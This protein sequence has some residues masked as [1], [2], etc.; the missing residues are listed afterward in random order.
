[1]SLRFAA[2]PA[3]NLLEAVAMRATPHP[4]PKPHWRRRSKRAAPA[5]EGRRLHVGGGAAVRQQH[6]GAGD[7][8]V[9]DDHVLAA[10]AVVCGCMRALAWLCMRGR[11]SPWPAGPSALG[12]NALSASQ[13]VPTGTHVPDTLTRNPRC[14]SVG[15]ATA[16]PSRTM[17]TPPALLGA[18]ADTAPATVMSICLCNQLIDR[19]IA[20]LF[21]GATP[22]AALPRTLPRSTWLGYIAHPDECLWLYHILGDNETVQ[23][24]IHGPGG[25]QLLLVHYS[26]GS[27]N[28][29]PHSS[30]TTAYIDQN[31]YK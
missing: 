15:T 4:A 3:C 29:L 8:A 30:F 22:D 21:T 27:L 14:C 20:P 16:V 31:I 18:H 10:C 17:H 11:C 12:N 9:L 5:A 7:A 2:A 13:Q 1:M 25:G 23:R 19:I 26:C 28:C 6:D 24:G